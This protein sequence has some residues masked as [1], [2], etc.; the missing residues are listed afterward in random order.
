M[1]MAQI[2]CYIPCERGVMVPVE[3]VFS[4]IGGRDE[5]VSGKSTF[6]VELEETS[7]ILR[8]ATN[9]S[10]VVLDEF[11]RGTSVNDGYSIAFS[12]LEFLKKIGC[13]VLF[14]THHHRLTTDFEG[15]NRVQLGHMSSFED[16]KDK[17]VTFLYKLVSG[18]S[19]K[20][21]GMNVALMSGISPSILQNAKSISSAFEDTAS[22]NSKDDNDDNNDNTRSS[23]QLHQLLLLKRLSQLLNNPST[24][25]QQQLVHFQSFI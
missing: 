25:L 10:L 15:D 20:S 8:N 7:T 9:R 24:S 11:G 17:T 1:V 18:K 13:P 16:E 14:S 23:N 22:A 4:R 21:F 12:V 6:M 2:G 3:R 5:I 19:G